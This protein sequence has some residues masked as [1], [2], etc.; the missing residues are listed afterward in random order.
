MNETVLCFCS[1]LS[2][3]KPLSVYVPTKRYTFNPM[4]FPGRTVTAINLYC[5]L[6]MFF[7]SCLKEFKIVF[8]ILNVRFLNWK[9]GGL[10]YES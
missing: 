1:A 9:M 2:S 10:N 3:Y 7:F 5:I 6:E 8:T 4:F